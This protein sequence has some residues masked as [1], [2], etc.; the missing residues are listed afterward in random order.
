MIPLETEIPIPYGF[1][2][3]KTLSPI[4]RSSLL[5][6]LIGFSKLSELILRTAISAFTSAPIRFASNSSPV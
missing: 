6:T 5:E 4:F 1:P 3:A 2:I